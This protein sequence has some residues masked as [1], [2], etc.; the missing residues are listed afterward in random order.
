[1]LIVSANH[2]SRNASRNFNAMNVESHVDSLAYR[3]FN[4]CTLT[5]QN[6]YPDQ[7]HLI[8]LL[9][10]IVL[11]HVNGSLYYHLRLNMLIFHD[12]HY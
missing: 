7:T 2:C 6:L 1:M 10:L 8:T 11:Y 12:T 5:Q 4:L 3:I 9:K